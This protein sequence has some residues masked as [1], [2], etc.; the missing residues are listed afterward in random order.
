MYPHKCFSN[1]YEAKKIIVDAI[2]SRDDLSMWG[3]SRFEE[4]GVN[5]HWKRD[6][7]LEVRAPGKWVDFLAFVLYDFK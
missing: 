6:G 4:G 3:I 2:E 7:K 1:S 5:L